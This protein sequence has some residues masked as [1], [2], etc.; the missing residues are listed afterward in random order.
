MRQEDEV[1][2]DKSLQ[3]IRN[4]QTTALATEQRLTTAATRRLSDQQELE[5][6][7]PP[8]IIVERTLNARLTSKT[9][10]SSN[11]GSLTLEEQERV[12][13]IIA[14]VKQNHQEVEAGTLL[15]TTFLQPE[16]SIG[17]PSR[18][19]PR[20]ARMPAVARDLLLE[21]PRVEWVE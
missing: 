20:S 12:Q 3:H 16:P 21:G 10:G 8:V 11:P 13:R 7:I 14:Q 15:S 19:K 4:L 17:S 6:P 1:Q 2:L 5:Q 18:L 9:E